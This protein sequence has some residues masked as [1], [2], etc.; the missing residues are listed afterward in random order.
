VLPIPAWLLPNLAWLVPIPGEALPSL[1]WLLPSLGLGLGPPAPGL[2]IPACLA[3]AGGLLLV[4]A[5]VS[6]TV[7]QLS[8][9]SRTCQTYRPSMV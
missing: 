2:S 4:P 6:P 5:L 7:R 1:G 9:E 3:I 8:P